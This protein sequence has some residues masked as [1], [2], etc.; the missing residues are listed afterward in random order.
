MKK[1]N[2]EVEK[3]SEQIVSLEDSYKMT[4]EKSAK[5]YTQLAL[6]EALVKFNHQQ[7]AA[8]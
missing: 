3:N 5:M 4:A 8:I 7:K 1:E 6:D 2:I